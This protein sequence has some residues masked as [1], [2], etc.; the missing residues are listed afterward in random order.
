V[1]HDC[2][3]GL[4]GFI[5]GRVVCAVAVGVVASTIFIAIS[6]DIRREGAAACRGVRGAVPVEVGVFLVV[7]I[8]CV[9]MG[10]GKGF[11]KVCD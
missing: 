11:T 10:L 6:C 4:V 2:L 8:G 5:V 7:G 9:L 1:V 3:V